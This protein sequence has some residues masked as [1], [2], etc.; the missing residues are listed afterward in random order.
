MSLSG[1]RD[2]SLI[3]TAPYERLA[4]R[5]YV[6]KFDTVT[7]SEAI[8]REI[9]GRR[10]G[11]YY[12]TP[13]KKDIPFIEEFLKENLP[14]IKYVV[15]HGQLA[16]A[17][18]ESRISKFYNQE[19][20][21]MVS[22]NII[23]NGLDLPH[24]NTIIVHRSNLFSLAAL[25]QLKGRVGRSSKRGYA[26]ITFKEN[27][28]KEN[29]KKRLSIIN[30]SDALG[31]GFNIA[32]QDLDM[33]GGGSIIGEEQSGFIREI[34]TELYHQLLEEEIIFQ[35]QKKLSND[36]KI[37]NKFQPVI[38]I[39]EEI[40]IPDDYI[41]D[42]DLRLSIY[43][44]ISNVTDYKELSDLSI[45]FADRFGAIPKPLDNLFN[46]IELKI[47][48]ISCNIEQLEFSRKGIV[49]GFYKNNPN[50]PEKLLSLTLNK[51]DHYSLRPDQKIFYD[52]RGYLNENRFNLAKKIITQIS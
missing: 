11:V 40:Y 39:P 2:L 7:I 14:D 26:Y 17:I 38:K 10:N 44:R 16:P 52:F 46:L 43:K 6:T 41:D 18:L 34:G 50:N 48:C 51:N 1:I 5:S 45:E 21:L 28:L 24:V 49:I 30:T 22:T 47:L 20:P 4:V 19:V 27:E 12:V 35:K 15:T 3:L 13:R 37:I 29:G 36:D 23:E 8:K 33:R 42:L 25:Y 9:Y 32:S 31:S